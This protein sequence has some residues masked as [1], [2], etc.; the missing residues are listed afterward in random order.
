M[1][2]LSKVEQQ[3]EK[4]VNPETFNSFMTKVKNCYSLERLYRVSSPAEINAIKLALKSYETYVEIVSMSQIINK[5]Q[6]QLHHDKF[7]KFKEFKTKCFN[8]VCFG[9]GTVNKGPKIKKSFVC[10]N[11]LQDAVEE[12]L[13]INNYMYMLWL[14]IR[15][16]PQYLT[17]EITWSDYRNAR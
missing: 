1:S 5:D 10:C 8:R 4:L 9:P 16:F 13:D 12:C 15:Y 11:N 14:K 2:K 17:H 7:Y 3:A 6:I